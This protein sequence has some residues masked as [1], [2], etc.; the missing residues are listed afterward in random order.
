MPKMRVSTNLEI[1]ELLS[2]AFEEIMFSVIVATLLRLSMQDL[3]NSLK[4]QTLGKI[5][6]GGHNLGFRI[7]GMTREIKLRRRQEDSG[8]PS[9]MTIVLQPRSG[10]DRRVISC[11]IQTIQMQ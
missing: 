7:N 9:P 8:R 2:R 3:L 5:R 1:S 6:M 11:K 4:R 10:L